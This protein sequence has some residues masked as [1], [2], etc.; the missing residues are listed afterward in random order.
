M[1]LKGCH[2]ARATAGIFRNM[3]C[4]GLQRHVES[5]ALSSCRQS[6][7]HPCRMLGRTASTGLLTDLRLCCCRAKHALQ[8]A[9][10][11]ITKPQKLADHAA[12]VAARSTCSGRML[13]WQAAGR[14]PVGGRCKVITTRQ[15]HNSTTSQHHIR[16]RTTT[17]HTN[18]YTTACS[19]LGS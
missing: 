16:A 10:H 14:R 18:H 3:Y 13:A 4:P 9:H 11:V 17:L 7:Q 6:C 1:R 5:A 8:L 12:G 15:L 2:S 19:S